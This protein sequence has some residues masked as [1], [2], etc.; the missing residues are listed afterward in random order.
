[1]WGLDWALCVVCV[2]IYDYSFSKLETTDTTK[3]AKPDMSYCIP[4]LTI[5]DIEN[6]NVT[7]GKDMLL[8]F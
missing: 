6:V 7:T 1:M 5:P 3:W 2:N 4:R 8:G